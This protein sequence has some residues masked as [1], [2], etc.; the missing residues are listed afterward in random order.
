MSTAIKA[1]FMPNPKQS[2]RLRAVDKRVRRRNSV[3]RKELVAQN[4]KQAHELLRQAV[5]A[6][7][8][9]HVCV[10]SVKGLTE[11]EV[12][13]YAAGFSKRA[14]AYYVKGLK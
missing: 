2:K 11:K 9:V 6:G 4:R 13:V 5:A 14:A 3:I 8:Y 10:H 12:F 1:E 7:I